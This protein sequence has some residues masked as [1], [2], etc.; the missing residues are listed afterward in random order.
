M[1]HETGAVLFTINLQSL[2]TFYERV[3]NMRV[4]RTEDDHIHLEAGLF[5]LT[6][7]Q[8]PERYAKN[9]HN[10]NASCRA[11]S[12]RHQAG[13][14]CERHREGARDRSATRRPT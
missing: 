5:R 12:Y 10:Q 4:L 9:N 3:A 8:I 13:V 7:H 11:R 2:A 14:S 6:V 1:K